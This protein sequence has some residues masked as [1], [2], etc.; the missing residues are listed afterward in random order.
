MSYSARILA[1]S[2]S[3]DGVRLTTFEVVF[4]RFILAEIEIPTDLVAIA[5]EA[6]E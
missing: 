6:S 5:A 1:D 2:M 3:P 4:P